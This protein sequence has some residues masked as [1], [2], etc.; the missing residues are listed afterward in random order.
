MKN[1]DKIIPTICG[2]WFIIVI[3]IGL[4]QPNSP[5]FLLEVFCYAIIG[6]LIGLIAKIWKS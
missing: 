2:L 5:Q 3:I 1:L 6:F 4:N